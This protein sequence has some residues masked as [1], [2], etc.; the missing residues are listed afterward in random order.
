MTNIEAVLPLT[1]PDVLGPEVSPGIWETQ[2][3]QGWV[4]VVAGPEGSRIEN[5]QPMASL[6]SGSAR[7][8]QCNHCGSLDTMF[9]AAD[10]PGHEECEVCGCVL[11]D[12]DACA[13]CGMEGA[14]DSS[15][16]QGCST[17]AS[18]EYT[19]TRLS[20]RRAEREKASATSRGFIK[21][22]LKMHFTNVT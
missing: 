1:D 13:N 6:A 16:L 9:V 21:Q 19:Q 7:M 15:P 5:G 8:G 3:D 11:V 4:M 2:A 14:V 18:L 12:F 10:L 17:C 20:R 22:P